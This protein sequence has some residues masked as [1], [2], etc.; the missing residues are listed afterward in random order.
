MWETEVISEAV[1]HASKRRQTEKKQ[2]A[3]DREK[4]DVMCT[5]SKQTNNQSINQSINQSS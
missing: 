2:V 3:K 4:T 1:L 5:E